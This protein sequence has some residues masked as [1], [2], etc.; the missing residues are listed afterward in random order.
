[1]RD[2]AERGLAVERLKH[3]VVVIPGIGGS[4]LR[5]PAGAAHWD[6]HR[7]RL[8][9]AA[10]RPDRLSLDARP[11]LTP[12]G[13]VPDIRLLGPFVL[14]GYAGLV[15]QVRRSF[16]GVR[17]DVSRPDRRPDPRADLVLFP[18]DF[19]KGIAPAAHRLAADMD[20][21]LRGLGP[22][23]RHRR[24][25]VVAHSMGGL[26]ARYWLG[27]L[28]GA[29]DCAALLTLGTPH[30]GAPKALDYLV[31]GVRVSRKRFAGLTRVLRG[32]PSMYDLLPRYPA[33]QR[34]G[35]GATLYPH[36]L[37]GA[38]LA[39]AEAKAAYQRHLDIETAWQDLSPQVRPE[40]VPA[41]ARGHAT[42]SR[43]VLSL[44][45]E[46][47]VLSVTKDA[48]LWLPNPQWHGDGSVPAISAVPLEL[49]ERRGTWRG[50]PER[51]LALASCAAVVDVLTAYTGASLSSVRG[52]EPERPWLGLD[53]DESVLAGEPVR[54][55]VALH[56]AQAEAETRVHVRAVAARGRPPR[57][58]PWVRGVSQDG[59]GCT[60]AAEIAEP[61]DAGLYTVE[62]T[63]T[64]VPGVGRLRATDELGVVDALAEAG[65]EEGRN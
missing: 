63:A 38:L 59:R 24:V 46:R 60:W 2:E 43:A 64:G 36:E 12:V 52:E 34:A 7:R 29:P 23:V 48:P 3:V 25:I 28:G 6:G 21:R 57:I 11:D 18:Y 44:R 17:V 45:E 26:V 50:Q 16:A 54:V 58:T 32:W 14:P 27:P 10:V 19:R 62:V 1:M 35:D 4:V 65:T 9:A 42:P 15:R 8:I 22:A 33:V 55:G 39:V 5:P 51:H 13:L 47:Q 37:D 20:A 53:L 61:L 30:R 40:V 41:Y 56:G 49:D 31:N